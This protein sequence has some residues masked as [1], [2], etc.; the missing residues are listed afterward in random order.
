MP[1]SRKLYSGKNFLHAQ[2][3]EELH[4]I[5]RRRVP[6]F[7][8]EYIE[9]GAED[10][11]TLNWNARVLKSIRFIPSTLID[12]SK[13]HQH[14]S[15]FN[16]KIDSPL[17]I[18][19]TGLNGMLHHKA[20]IALARAANKYNI[21]F[22]L[23]T[24][25][26]ATMEEVAEQAGG[27]LWMQLYVMTDKSI[28][29][30]II[31]RADRAG[32]EALVFTSDANV[33]GN[34]E[35][36]RRNYRAPAKLTYRNI[37]NVARYPRWIF[38]VLVPHGVPRFEN[39]VDFMPPEAKSASGG[40]AVFPKLF[41]PN[42]SWQ[43]VEWLRKVWPRKLLIK[44]VLNVAD[45]KRAA[46]IGCDG[47]ILSNHGGRQLDSC[48]SPI[49]VLPNIIEAVGDNITVIIDSGFRRGT[50]VVKAMALGAH[51]VMI[52]RA[53][54]Y[55]LA[56]GGEKGANHALSI[57]TTEI[58]RVLGQ[59]GCQSFDDVGPHLLVQD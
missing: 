20:D 46:D 31:T 23:S 36:D 17:I 50:D 51:A 37:F 12:T 32:Y 53:T 7:A 57:L 19:P 42:I 26:N 40:V 48:I 58:D 5:A 21:P 13:R 16:Q 15:L 11:N 25:A 38:D 27:R 45:A 35:W 1:L 34:R 41:A 28:A 55:G 8:M 47:V 52:G 9:G 18:A 43:D 14:V 56:A 49:E 3:I 39:I 22:T 6:N 59:L 10:E 2:S 44:G 54:L 24:V 33:F 4:A 30:N 29:E